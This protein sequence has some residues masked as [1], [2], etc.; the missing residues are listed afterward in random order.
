M[1][2][3]FINYILLLHIKYG[4]IHDNSGWYTPGC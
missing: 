1:Y 3:S 4:I 2:N